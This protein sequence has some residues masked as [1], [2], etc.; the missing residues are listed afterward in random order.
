MTYHCVLSSCFLSA[1]ITM[2]VQVIPSALAQSIIVKFLTKENVK[3]AE[4]PR[5]LRVQFDDE[6]LSR[7]YMYDWSKSFEEGRTE[8]ENMRKLYLLQS[9][10]FLEISRRLFNRFSDITTNHQRS[11]LLKS[12]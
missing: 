4:I 1:L 8:V 6:T 3:P 5:R 12:S 9:Q 10:H 11:L 7:I 2:S